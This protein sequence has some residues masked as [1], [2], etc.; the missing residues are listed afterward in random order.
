MFHVKHRGRLLVA[1]LALSLLA[2]GCAQLAS[3]EGWAAPVADGDRIFVQLERGTISAGSFSANGAFTEEWR[4]PSGTDDLDFDG[5]YATPVV[6]DD[7]VYAVSYDGFAIALDQETGRPDWPAIVELKT[8]VVATPLLLGDALYIPTG[9]GELVVLSAADG[10]ETARF[11]EPNGRIWA[12]P[13]ADGGTI[14]VGELD[15]RQLTAVD[16]LSGELD[17][18]Q[19]AGGGLSSDL[20]LVG[21]FVLTGS[22]DR[23]LRAFDQTSPGAQRWEYDTNGWITSAPLISGSVVYSA[24]LRGEVF[25]LDVDTGAEDWLY[26]EDDLEFRAKPILVDG[27]LVVADRDGRLRGLDPATGELRWGTDLDNA[28]LFAD[29]LLFD[30]S[31]LYVTKDG[32][33]LRVSPR[34][35][36]TVVA[37]DREG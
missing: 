34:D 5:F 21:D 6:D 25:A 3:P 7:H 32:D 8:N 37:F 35:G 12:A 22:L 9:D 28:K 17:W 27:V 33:L 29:P 20:A 26:T 24:T 23:S 15:A 14:Y 10:T 11:L 1:V 16:A 30:G 2:S 31:I 19:D 18:Q 36:S 4:F 13:V